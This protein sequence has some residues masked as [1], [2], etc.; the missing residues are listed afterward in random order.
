MKKGMMD[1]T[2]DFEQGAYIIIMYS[3]RNDYSEGAAPAVMQALFDT[4]LN[5]T[6]GYGGDDYCQQAADKL[7][8]VCHAPDAQVHFTVGGTQTNVLIIHSL[9]RSFE[10]VISAASGHIANHETGGV[11]AKGHK[12]CTI[13]TPDGK[14]TPTLVEAVLAGHS[15]EH[16]V[17]PKMVYISNSTELGTIYTKEELQGLRACCDAHGLYLFADGARVA[18]AIAASDVTLVDMAELC[19]VFTFGGTKNGLLFGEAVVFAP[20]VDA[21]H[22]RYFMKQHGAL[23]AK[24]RLL[25]VQFLA[26][27]EDDL[28]LKLATHANAQSARMREGLDALHCEYFVDSP[29][30]QS[31]VM[32]ENKVIEAL[33]DRGYEF[34]IEGLEGET[35]TCIRIV[36]SWATP[37]EAVQQFLADLGTLL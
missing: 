24:G 29:T 35:V 6:V 28:W 11:E 20:D 18:S 21:T 10:A 2:L 30:N 32:L 3:F 7:R 23:L 34:E 16:M 1:K 9:L 22:F 26:L 31:F 14:L 25:G 37:Q 33:K 5:Q 17:A 13:E 27:L 15:S 36:T 4:N 19:H 8:Q 12:V